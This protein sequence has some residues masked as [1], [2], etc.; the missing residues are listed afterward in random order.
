MEILKR[1]KWPE[2]QIKSQEKIRAQFMKENNETGAV[3]ASRKIREHTEELRR[4]V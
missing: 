2:N 3:G 1:I 4:L